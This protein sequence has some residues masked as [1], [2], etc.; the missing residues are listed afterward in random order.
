MESQPVI[1]APQLAVGGA[2]DKLRIA[3]GV[4]GDQI[5]AAD[6][7][8]M[9]GVAVARFLTRDGVSSF[10]RTMVHVELD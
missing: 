2:D 8:Q 3:D 1:G 5:E 10:P 9:I 7:A 6:S 4:W